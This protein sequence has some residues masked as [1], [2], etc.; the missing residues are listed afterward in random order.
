MKSRASWQAHGVLYTAGMGL[1][2]P[3]FWRDSN[4]HSV[5]WLAGYCF[6]MGIPLTCLRQGSLSLL[7]AWIAVLGLLIWHRLQTAHDLAWHSWS[8]WAAAWFGIAGLYWVQWLFVPVAAAFLGCVVAHSIWQFKESISNA[9][10]NGHP[11]ASALRFPYG[12][13][14]FFLVV[15]LALA[16]GAVVASHWLRE[17]EIYPFQNGFW[18]VLVPFMPAPSWL[19]KM[20]VTSSGAFAFATLPAVFSVLALWC[21]KRTSDPRVVSSIGLLSFAAV[22]FPALW[23]IGDMF[24]NY[25]T[26]EVESGLWSR[27]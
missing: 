19:H 9:G 17:H 22:G 18:N 24:I 15:N 27:P 20:L 10:A 2:I 8:A 21:A 3:A 11:G 16:S 12:S 14:V 7:P 4:S 6:V 23:V 1:L 26:F 5:V 25:Y 13:T